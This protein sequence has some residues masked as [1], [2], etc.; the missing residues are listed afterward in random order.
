MENIIEKLQKE[1]GLSEDQAVKS[2]NVIKEYMDKEDLHVD[3]EKFFK[4]KYEHFKDS[5]SNFF[6]KISNKAEDWG[7]KIGDKVEDLTTDAKRKIR[8]ASKKE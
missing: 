1:V 6:S 3:W 8:D 7:D 4:G 2:L 5:V